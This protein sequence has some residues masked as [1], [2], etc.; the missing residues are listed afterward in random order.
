MSE[1]VRSCVD[2]RVH[3]CLCM[4]VCVRAC[5]HA[6]VLVCLFFVCVRGRTCQYGVSDLQ[7]LKGIESKN[8]YIAN[9]NS[10]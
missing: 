8:A 7:A 3:V 1:C 2:V 6:C 9:A 4:N 10:L 5:V